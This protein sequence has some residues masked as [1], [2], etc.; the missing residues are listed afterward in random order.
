MFHHYCH[1]FPC[2]N[3]QLR[4]PEIMLCSWISFLVWKMTVPE[5]W[6]AAMRRR[7]PIH[8]EYTALNP[9]DNFDF[10]LDKCISHLSVFNLQHI[11]ATERAEHVTTLNTDGLLSWRTYTYICMYISYRLKQHLRMLPSV[12][13][14]VQR[15]DKSTFP[16]WN[17]TL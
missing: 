7:F 15:F 14:S 5:F 4:Y 3:F 6:L 17:I 8:V 9:C 1:K 11:H 10:F 13:C 16:L 12:F 2:H